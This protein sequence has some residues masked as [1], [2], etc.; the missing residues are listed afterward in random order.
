MH[1]D[2]ADL[3]IV[4]GGFTGL[5]AALTAKLR[6]PE[7]DVVLLEADRTA[8]GASGRNGGFADP[9]LTHGLWNGLQHFPDEI[10]ELQRLGMEN[11]DGFVADIERLGIDARLEKA[12]ALSVATEAYQIDDLIEYGSLLEGYGEKI[13]YFDQEAVRREV[14]SPTYKYGVWRHAG[15]NVDPA[16][17]AWGLLEAVTALGVRVYDDTP[18]AKIERAGAG[19]MLRAG[20]ASVRSEKVVLATNAFRSPVSAMRR[21]TIP[22]WDYALMTE[23][24]DRAQIDSIGWGRRQ[25][26]GDSGNQFHYY[27]WT[28]DDRILFGGYDAIYHYGSRMDS[29]FEQRRESFEGLSSRFFNTFPQL[30]G[31]RFSHSWGGPIATTTR[32]CMDVGSAHGGRVSWAIGYTGLGVVASRFGARVALDLLDA[33][34]A[35]HLALRFVRKRPWR[36]PLEP[37]RSIGVSLTQRALAKS[38][39]S[40]GRRGPWLK[41]IDAMGLGFDS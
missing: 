20:N 17:L 9:S 18:I 26:I 16:R 29:A 12:G 11:Y 7:R 10:N 4:G 30:E 36:W 32:F 21:A 31:I 39:R 1:S 34:D 22:V 24:L 5:W 27:R 13:E 35:P 2:E 14:D 23:P 38:D 19:M 25:G 33:P 40:Q 37:V 3:A 28:K 6:Q 8:E 41:L 15:A